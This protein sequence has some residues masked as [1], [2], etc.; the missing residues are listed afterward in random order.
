LEKNANIKEACRLKPEGSRGNA[1]MRIGIE[2]RG[3][4]FT[5]FVS[6]NGEPMHPVGDP[7]TLHI[8]GPFYVGIGF[9]SHVPDKSDTAVLSGVV[10]ENATGKI[11]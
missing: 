1:P 3:D 11:R 4:S 5:L 8:D 2:K 9:C 6:L 7:A 10:L